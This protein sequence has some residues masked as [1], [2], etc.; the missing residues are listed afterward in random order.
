M[1][2]HQPIAAFAEAELLVEAPALPRNRAERPFGL[3]PAL[4]GLSF[5]GFAG[6]LA[7]LCATFM[8]AE[9]VVPTGIFAVLLVAYFVVP[10]WWTRVAPEPE[11][12]VQSWDE[13]LREGIETGAGHCGGRAAVVQVL[14]M[15]AMLVGW[16][17]IIATIRAAV[18]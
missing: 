6:F 7:I 8:N 13:F 4:F 15:P 2:I 5:A 18:M 3:H 11:G 14:I 10:G 1:T 16:A 12:R 9:L 17:L